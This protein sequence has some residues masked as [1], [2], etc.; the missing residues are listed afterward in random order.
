MKISIRERKY[1]TM[2]LITHAEGSLFLLES[3]TITIREISFLA[4]TILILRRCYTNY[5]LEIEK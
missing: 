1:S 3:R 4:Y 5:R 2:E